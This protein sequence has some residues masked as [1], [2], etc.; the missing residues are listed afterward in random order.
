MRL[1]FGDHLGKDG[2]QAIA[3][4]LGFTNLPYVEKFIMDFEMNY[5]ISKRMDCVLRGGM[6]MPFHSGLELRRL[7]VDVDLLTRLE[8]AEVDKAMESLDRE[9][10]G[11]TI[12]K[13]KPK[14]P[15]PIRTCPRTAWNMPRA[16]TS[17]QP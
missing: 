3:R 11:L 17:S 5:H 7:S 9:L 1:H 2:V 15:Y 12:R 10:A 6:C 4:E 14:D 8:S 13:Y 16:L